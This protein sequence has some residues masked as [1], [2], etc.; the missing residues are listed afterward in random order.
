MTHKIHLRLNAVRAR[1]GLH[2]PH[3]WTFRPEQVTCKTCLRLSQGA[4]Q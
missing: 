1:C 3:S 2:S 4:M